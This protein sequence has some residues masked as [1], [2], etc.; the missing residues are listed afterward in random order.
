MHK[1]QQNQNPDTVHYIKKQ[2]EQISRRY[3]YWK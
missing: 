3:Q 1:E 2:V